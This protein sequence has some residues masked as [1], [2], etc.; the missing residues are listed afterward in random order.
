MYGSNRTLEES[1]IKTS[2]SIMKSQ[3]GPMLLLIE[4]LR[5]RVH[6]RFFDRVGHPLMHLLEISI[7]S[8]NNVIVRLI[9]IMDRADNFFFVNIVL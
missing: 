8:L 3:E 2:L 7:F 5:I 1:T 4:R 6:P 9:T